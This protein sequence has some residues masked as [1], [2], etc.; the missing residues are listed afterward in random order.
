M[1]LKTLR[2]TPPWDWPED[3]GFMAKVRRMFVDVLKSPKDWEAFARP[4]KDA[5]IRR[6]AF[7]E[8]TARGAPGWK[9]LG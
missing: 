9:D 4:I 5:H 3:A 1:D 8:E 6:L 2:D 7:Q